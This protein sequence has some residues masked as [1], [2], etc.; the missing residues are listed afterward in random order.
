MAGHV[1]SMPVDRL[2]ALSGISV[3]TGF[4]YRT[5]AD[6]VDLSRVDRYRGAAYG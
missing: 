6:S 1:Q 4:D 2:V 3:A 5:P